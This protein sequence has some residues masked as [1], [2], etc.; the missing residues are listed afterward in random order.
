MPY[1]KPLRPDSYVQQTLLRY[2][3]CEHYEF[4]RYVLLTNFPD[5][6]DMF[7]ALG[8]HTAYKKS[9]EVV[10]NKELDCSIVNFGIGS[11]LAGMVMHCLSYLDQVDA[12]IMLGLAGGLAEKLEVG[13]FVLPT[14][15]IR[16]EGTSQLYLHHDA[17]ALPN[18]K[19]Q[20]IIEKTAKQMKIKTRSGIFKTTD[21]RMWEFDDEF[22]R[23]L[24]EQRVVAIEMEIATLF[25]V[26]FSL[27]KPI[28]AVMLIS[29]L[30]L[31]HSGIKRSES[32]KEILAEYC[33]KHLNLGIS[34]IKNLNKEKVFQIGEVLP[35][36]W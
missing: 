2:S 8:K 33:T 22:S 36:E 24:K 6:V 4:R 25:S 17:P 32:T 16:D 15:S 5:Y 1:S 30:P 10:H 35:Y 14:A 21:Y 3:G 34:S 27:G 7:K 31:T 18:F 13:D 12:V 28:G 9:W 29:D 20:H 23:L 11:P 19:V 26:G